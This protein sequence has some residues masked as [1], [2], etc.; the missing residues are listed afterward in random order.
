[1]KVAGNSS[2]HMFPTVIRRWSTTATKPP[3]FGQPV[4]ASHP[5]LRPSFLS[6]SRHILIYSPSQTR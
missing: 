5:H 3:K 2:S 4:F 1:M 6:T